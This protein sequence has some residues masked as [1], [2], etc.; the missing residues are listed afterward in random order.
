MLF[1]SDT[2]NGCSSVAL[3]NS[4]FPASGL[5]AGTYSINVTIDQQGT[6]TLSVD[7][8]DG[9]DFSTLANKILF[10]LDPT[11]VEQTSYEVDTNNTD[12]NKIILKSI[13]PGRSITVSNG[14][15]DNNLLNYVTLE[16][17]D[18]GTYPSQNTTVFSIGNFFI[19]HIRL[20]ENGISKSYLQFVISNNSESKVYNVRWNNNEI[21][22][23]HV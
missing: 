5:S 21:G 16:N 8:K 7:V 1:R 4:N 2:I 19:K 13:L 22:R 11:T 3:T 10:K 23:A 20:V 14:T 15:T 18:Y 6:S 9:C 17:I 12:T